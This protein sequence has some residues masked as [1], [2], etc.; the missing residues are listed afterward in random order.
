MIDKKC[1]CYVIFIRTV[2]VVSKS[3]TRPPTGRVFSTDSTTSISEEKARKLKALFGVTAATHGQK[4]SG[5]PIKA[6]TCI[7]D[8]TKSDKNQVQKVASVGSD[9]EVVR[10]DKEE[11]AEKA[12]LDSGYI[13]YMDNQRSK[14]WK[15]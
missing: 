11:S 9:K 14:G 12:W 4:P 6:V 5:M 1:S 10:E 2:L 15:S 7:T 3:L 8:S 13:E